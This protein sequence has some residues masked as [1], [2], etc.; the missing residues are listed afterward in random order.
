MLDPIEPCNNVNLVC[1][2]IK[3]YTDLGRNPFPVL[4][5]LGNFKNCYNPTY[6]SRPQILSV[7]SNHATCFGRSDHLHALNT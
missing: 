5:S 1:Y 3:P 2:N 4:Y 6:R 7:P